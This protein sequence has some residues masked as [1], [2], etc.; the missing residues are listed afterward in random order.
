MLN[1]NN[2]VFSLLILYA[3]IGALK[4][5]VYSKGSKTGLL[6]ILYAGIGALKRLT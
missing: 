5:I 1:S 2:Q 3:G 4:Q 6:L